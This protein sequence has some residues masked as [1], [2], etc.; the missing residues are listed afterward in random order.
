MKVSVPVSVTSEERAALLAHAQALGVPLDSLLRRAVLQIIGTAPEAASAQQLN[1]E[2]F[3]LAFEELADIIPEGVPAIP[4]EAISR[5]SIY[6][7]E[8]E[9]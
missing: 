7:R 1:P 9:W 2:E 8:D 6:T 5:E 3:E 4:D